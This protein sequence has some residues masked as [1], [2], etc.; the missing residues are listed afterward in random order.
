MLKV[1]LGAVNPVG[2][3][4]ATDAFPRVRNVPAPRFRRPVALPAIWNPASTRFAVPETVRS[5]F[6]VIPP[7]RVLAPDPD[8]PR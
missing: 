6:T 1:M 7:A 2:K 4:V 8:R 3:A 5:P